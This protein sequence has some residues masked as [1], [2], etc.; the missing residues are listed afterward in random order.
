MPGLITGE[1]N[2]LAVGEPLGGLVAHTLHIQQPR[3]SGT[4]GEQQQ[5]RVPRLVANAQDP[6]P[7]G[8]ERGPITIPEPHR[9]RPICLPQVYR[10]VASLSARELDEEEQLGVVGKLIDQRSVQPSQ[11]AFC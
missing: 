4:G 10:G 2:P 11:I 7:I 8:R 1:Q 3:F 6:L 5:L 9:G